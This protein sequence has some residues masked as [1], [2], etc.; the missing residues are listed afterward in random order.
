M[1]SSVAWQMTLL[2][3][4]E[5][6]R[7]K[8]QFSFVVIFPLAIMAMFLVIAELLP[9]TSA[10]SRQMIVPMALYLSVTSVAFS[11]TAAPVADLRKMGTLRLLGTTPLGRTRLILTHMP[12]RLV[13]AFLQVAVLL[14]A[15]LVLG[16]V[17]ADA[18]M[19][20]LALAALG[21]GM[22]GALG[23]LLGGVLPSAES[24]SNV[25]TLIQLSVFFLSGLVFPLDLLPSAVASVLLY[26][27]TTFFADLM[28][29]QLPAG[30]PAHP[31]LL[32]VAVVVAATAALTALAVA[33]FKWDQ[34]ENG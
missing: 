13:L 17:G 9:D 34:G 5:L 12:V 1:T 33:T 29:A 20:L 10:E 23:Y 25:G 14:V 19:P 31:A 24:A 16:L 28:V 27:P 15:G 4:R 2:H 18:L 22:F 11:A 7:D 26:S 32:S 8:R 30:D 21:L 6:V 3:A